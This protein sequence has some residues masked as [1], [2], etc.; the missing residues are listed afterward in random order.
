MGPNEVVRS[1]A[2]TT[3]FDWATTAAGMSDDSLSRDP[4][5][6]SGTTEASSAAGLS[7]RLFMVDLQGWPT[8]IPTYVAYIQGSASNEL[9]DGTPRWFS[10]VSRRLEHLQHYPQ[11]GLADDAAYPKPPAETIQTAWLIAHGLFDASTPTPSVVPAEDGGV[12]FA[13]HKNGWDL[14]ISVL[15]EETL[16]WARNRSAGENWVSPL[17]KSFEKVQTVLASL[18]S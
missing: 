12:E 14:V 9:P 13:W 10:Y 2:T 8:V 15:L 3:S 7:E 6:S 16:V 4:V 1:A 11:P 5:L 17:S 18:T